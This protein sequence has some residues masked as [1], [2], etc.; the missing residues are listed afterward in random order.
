ME[1]RDFIVTPIVIILVFAGAYLIRPRVTDSL[2]RRY[3][4]PALAVKALGAVALGFIYQFYYSGGDTYNFHTHGSRHIWE[5]FMDSPEKGFGL[6]FS[7][8]VHGEYYEYSSRIPF[9]TDPSTFFIIRLAAIF[10]L[11]TFSS[12]SATA[13]C[14]AVLS[15]I[16]MW[17]FFLT[18][19]RKYPQ[20]HWQLALATFFIPSV[21]FW[22]SGVLKDSVTLACLG[23]ATYQ[24]YK[25]FFEQK[26][27]LTN[28]LLLIMALYGIFSVKKFILQAY[29]PAVIVW[30]F[31]EKFHHIQSLVLKMMLIPFTTILVIVSAY[32]TIV[33]VGEDDARYSISNISKTAKVTAY[34]IRYWSGRDAG[35]GY[36]LGELDGT[37][38]S[39]VRLAPQAI[40]VSLF[41]PYIWE[42]RNPLM[43]LSAFESLALLLFTIYTIL[44]K[45][46]TILK[47]LTNS[48]VIFC[49]IFSI[50]FAFAVGVSTFN[51]GT[52]ARYK[53]PLLPF[54]LVALI[55][56]L[57]YSK[58]DKKLSEFESNE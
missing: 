44:I 11:F 10:D 43:L 46:G 4:L 9:F 36:E 1:L 29:L 18:F 21:F 28:F 30:I 45:R 20:A 3:F 2:T 16:G 26:I 55:L 35:S 7:S 34:D 31:A 52:L 49:L 40:N 33:K 37:I 27:T 8:G 38:G 13:I 41:R 54:F 53:I 23:I 24:F 39:L 42:V 25:V 12:Y 19:Y 51:F 32:Y 17:M 57:D 58:S 50:S 5:A 48:S 14:F 15:F 6:I 22:G 47:A 56:I